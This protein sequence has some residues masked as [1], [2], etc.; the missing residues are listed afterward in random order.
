MVKEIKREKDRL[1]AD[2]ELE[3]LYKS[4]RELFK[5]EGLIGKDIFD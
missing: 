2:L 5:K 1:F 3:A 4:V